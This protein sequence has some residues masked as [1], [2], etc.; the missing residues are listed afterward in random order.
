MLIAYILHLLYMHFETHRCVC[1]YSF[2]NDILCAEIANIQGPFPLHISPPIHT[3]SSDFN[4]EPRAKT[5]FALLSSTN[6]ALHSLI[7][8]VYLFKTYKYIERMSLTPQ[9]FAHLPPWCYKI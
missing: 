7:A 8:N 2:R 3:G 1:K 4:V 9:K 5:F 6:G